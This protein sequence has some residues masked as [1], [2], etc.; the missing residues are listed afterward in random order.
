MKDTHVSAEAY[1]K[2]RLAV[3][4]SS[5]GKVVPNFHWASMEPAGLWRSTTK[6]MMYFLKAHLGYYGEDWKNLLAKTTTSTVN[7]SSCN[8]IGLAWMLE[9]WEMLGDFAWHNGQTPGQKSVV[10][11]AKDRDTAVVI[12]S[13]KA[14]K[15]W[16]NIFKRYSI[17]LLSFSILKILL[18]R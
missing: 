3:G 9:S 10:V 8:Q 16:H 11:C 15:I 18:S 4:H 13:N 5:N 2:K 12:L 7:E 6:D 17:E 14:P 1:D